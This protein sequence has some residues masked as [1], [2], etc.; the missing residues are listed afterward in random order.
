MP[1]ITP[2]SQCQRLADAGIPCSQTVLSKNVN[3]DVDVLVDDARVAEDPRQT[4]LS[5]SV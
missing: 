4:V 1:G 2:E 5:L 3:D